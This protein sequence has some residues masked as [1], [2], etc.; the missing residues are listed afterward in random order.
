[1]FVTSYNLSSHRES[2]WGLEIELE[3]RFGQ[4]VLV[5]VVAVAL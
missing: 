2:N 1:M 4:V 5:V 3:L